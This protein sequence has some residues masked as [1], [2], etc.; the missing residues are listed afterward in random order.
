M[1]RLKRWSGAGTNELRAKRPYI[2]VVACTSFWG[3]AFIAGRVA[4]QQ[5]P[6]M[7][8][9]ALRFSIAAVVLIGWMART[10]D[11][12]TRPALKQLVSTAVLGLF[13]VF[14]YNV[15]FFGALARIPA[16]Q[17]ALFMALNPLMTA[18]L[19]AVALR[20]KLT[21]I[22]WTAFAI[23][24]MGV[25]IIM[26]KGRLA[27]GLDS[28]RTAIGTGDALMLCAPLCWAVYTVVGKRALTGM[29]PLLA[30]TCAVLWGA[31]FLFCGAWTEYDA[32]VWSHIEFPAWFAVIYLGVFGTA[33]SFVWWYD[34]VAALGPSRTAIFNNLVP[35]FAVTLSSV[36][37]NEPIALSTLAGGGLVI[38]GVLLV[39]R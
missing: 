38:F 17:A 2:K 30:T 9:A 10:G 20:E 12:I 6:P 1:S 37:L 14:F 4:A 23:S 21:K 35:V 28:I 22:K 33:L 27:A 34:A 5:L 19:G 29:S 32:I 13:G 39:N 15:C 7:T 25:V 8:A 31:V 11:T 18:A 16:G 3:G 36:V 24:V 26:T